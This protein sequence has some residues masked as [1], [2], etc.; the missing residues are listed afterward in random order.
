MWEL[1]KN[2]YLTR[3]R[4]GA[5][6]QRF[7]KQLFAVS[8]ERQPFRGLIQ[9]LIIIK[10]FALSRLRVLALKYFLSNTQANL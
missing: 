3:R 5:K 9:R 1:D 6:A 8:N 2:I 4:E 10:S 7:F